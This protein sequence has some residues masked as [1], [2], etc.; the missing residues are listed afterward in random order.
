MAED[1]KPAFS[2]A[3]ATI[4]S[5]QRAGGLVPAV[6]GAAHPCHRVWYFVLPIADHAC[7]TALSRASYAVT[8]VWLYRPRMHIVVCMCVQLY[9]PVTDFSRE[10]TV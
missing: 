5:L 3:V 8:C 2:A 9:G 4:S 1:A 7:V 10:H 6:L